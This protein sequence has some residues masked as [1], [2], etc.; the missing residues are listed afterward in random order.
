MPSG[1][2]PSS[3]TPGRANSDMPGDTRAARA[4]HGDTREEGE[5][6]MTSM[7]HIAVIGAGNMGS[8]YGGNLARVGYPVTLIDLNQEH[9]DAIRRTGLHLSGLHGEFTVAVEAVTDPAQLVGD[10]GKVDV[11]I[12]CTNTYVTRQAGETARSIIKADGFV[13]T[14]QNGMGNLDILAEVV[15]PERLLGGLTFHSG[16]LQGPGQVRHTNHGPTYLGELD[17]QKTPRL[18]ALAEAMEKAG[19]N[20]VVEA[21]IMATI[22][23]KFVH[24]CGLNALCALTGL[25]PGHIRHVPELDEF[26]TYIIE[27]TLAL[28]QAKGITLPDPDPLTSIKEYSAQKFH[29][30]SMQQHLDRHSPTEIDALNGYVARESARLGLAAPYND[31]LTRLMKGRQYIPEASSHPTES[32]SERSTR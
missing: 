30:V 21:D 1:L 25:R 14:L 29:R 8:I 17:R 19:M 24:N 6:N 7:P 27:E 32:A 2:L 3:G 9:I 5:N 20:P 18:A 26:Q 15:G 12:I 4:P 23:G 22:W 28:V 10:R 13:L 11:A 31:A 16:E